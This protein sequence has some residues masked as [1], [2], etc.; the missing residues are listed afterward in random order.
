MYR[1]RVMRFWVDGFC[2]VQASAEIPMGNWL[3]GLGG[4][5]IIGTQTVSILT[6]RTCQ[7]AY[8]VFN[9]WLR[10]LTCI[11]LHILF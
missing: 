11:D 2:S 1:S 3:D 8:P 9:G 4:I 5:E 10:N 6:H 7:S